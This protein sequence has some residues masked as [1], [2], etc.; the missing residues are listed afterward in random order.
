MNFPTINELLEQ[1]SHNQFFSG[2]A[3]LMVLGAIA[4]YCRAVPSKV[5]NWV[6][7]RA[8]MELEVQM[9]EEAYWWFTCWLAEQRYSKKRARNLT[10]TTKPESNSNDDQYSD[11]MVT[12]D[13]HGMPKIH[14][15]P[16][17]GIHWLWW[18]G[19]PMIV[20]KV[21][22]ESTKKAGSLSVDV[23]VETYHIQILTRNRD[24][25]RQ[26]IEE[27]YLVANPPSDARI[28]LLTPRYS[29]WGAKVKL[30]PR[31]L[32]S[33]FLRDGVLD[34]LVNDV[35]W[36]LSNEQWY[37]QRGIPYR[38]GYLLYGPPG[39]GK[40]S[41]IKA[42]ASEVK[43]DVCVISLGGMMGDSELNSLFAD[44]PERALVL[45]ED[46]DCVTVKREKG[47]KK[48]EKVSL[49]ALLNAIDG[50]AANEGHVL[51]MTT[52]HIENLDPALIRPG[53]C[54]RQVLIDNADSSQATRLFGR[55]FTDNDL[56]IEFGK[57]LKPNTSVATLQGHLLKAK[58]PEEAIAAL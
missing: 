6:W 39:N 2:G 21:R 53:R 49:S 20:T 32:E 4:A 38:R 9:K 1:L 5:F 16:S 51:F 33:I 47:K 56:A 29:G 36:F 46:I 24:L 18:R 40:S 28:N 22:K 23:E 41:T 54:D 25:C 42:I 11:S 12:A 34:D 17:P 50:V 55:F 27:A 7:D 3:I 31:P 57:R 35:K 26:L 8:F 48:E 13:Q 43:L 15:A 14:L 44:L 10:V 19:R 30:R 37:V 45:L 58:T 52:N